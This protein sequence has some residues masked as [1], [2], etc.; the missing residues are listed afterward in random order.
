MSQVIL[1]LQSGGPVNSSITIGNDTINKESF[2]NLFSDEA[3]SKYLATKNVDKKD[4]E[5]ITNWVHQLQDGI[6][7]N[8]IKYDGNTAKIYDTSY[9]VH[10]D[11]GK[12]YQSIA[13]GVIKDF[14]KNATLA[15]PTADR[16]KSGGIE[17]VTDNT[18]ESTTAPKFQFGFLDNLR[19]VV[20]KG[21]PEALNES[22][23]NFVKNPSWDVWKQ[24]YDSYKD[25]IDKSDL[26]FSDTTFK[27]KEAYQKE[28]SNLGKAI[29]NK[30]INAMAQSFNAIGEPGIV[31]PVSTTEQ[32]NLNNKVQSKG[33]SISTPVQSVDNKPQNISSKGE[34]LSTSPMDWN[35]LN[36]NQ[37]LDLVSFGLDAASLGASFIPGYGNLASGGLGLLGTAVSTINGKTDFLGTL[38]NV[39]LD[40]TG[41][42]PG[43]G[44]TAKGKK[45]V[46]AAKILLPIVSASMSSDMTNAVKE[47]SEGKF[48]PANLAIITTS[49]APAIIRNAK[50]YSISKKLNPQVMHT[51]RTATGNTISV[52]P[53][54]LSKITAASN[55]VNQ[56]NVIKNITGE[57]VELR[58][59]LNNPLYKIINRNTSR[60][61]VYP[62]LIDNKGNVSR[63]RVGSDADIATGS[64]VSINK[65]ITKKVKS[66]KLGSYKDTNEK[67]ISP[68]T[69]K[70]GGIIKAQAGVKTSATWSKDMDPLI[71]PS[72]LFGLGQNKNLYKQL[73]NLQNSYYGI[74][75]LAGDNFENTAYKSPEVGKY[76]TE[77]NNVLNGLGNN[78]AMKKLEDTNKFTF[79]KNANT[80]D[81]VNTWNDNLFSGMTN[82]RYLLGKK[83]DF[84]PEQEAQRKSAFA[85]EGY[86][87]YLDYNNMYKLKPINL[88]EQKLNA[89]VNSPILMGTIKP[90]SVEGGENVKTPWYNKLT[91]NAVSHFGTLRF[92]NNFWYNSRIKPN[93]IGSYQ[94]PVEYNAKVMYDLPSQMAYNQQAAEVNR[95]GARTVSAD[96][97]IN[98]ANMLEHT[99]LANE[100]QEKG[101]LANKRAFDQSLEQA[102]KIANIN[103][104]N[105]VQAA[106]KN[107]EMNAGIQNAR[108]SF[109]LAQNRQINENFDNFLQEVE[110]KALN[111]KEITRNID[112]QAAQ[113]FYSTRVQKAADALRNAEQNYKISNPNKQWLNSQEYLNA[114]R[115]YD[116]DTNNLSEEFYQS[117]RNLGSQSLSPLFKKGGSLSEATQM[118]MHNDD[119]FNKMMRFKVSEFDKMMKQLSGF[120]TK[121]IHN[122]SKCK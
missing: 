47:I 11:L 8:K 44:I 2:N 33:T 6:N 99:K 20:S 105:R 3:I 113:H 88:V 49:L 122:N 7:N 121:L 23:S 4:I 25:Y 85:K 82:M 115:A 73:N 61:V 118:I 48:T 21:N 78:F 56:Q 10:D 109:R 63:I 87:W 108:E 40:I 26:D 27:S 45:L 81:K 93:Y 97:S 104:E 70:N 94:T 17:S 111:N 101:Q 107:A 34:S 92:L 13:L 117:M 67:Y 50:S 51:I 18:K 43:L 24:A 28:L 79:S 57:A 19:K 95:M 116:V 96:Q 90:T 103:T 53:E 80:S 31:N 75:T 16:V 22:Y 37:K 62:T 54:E 14:S 72:I 35:K 30:D 77:F 52:T 110:K 86:N 5:P 15:L 46:N 68:Q 36:T 71:T 89:D 60:Q 112:M 76:Q 114:R 38:G 42:I 119:E 100:L 84:T 29:S 32:P 39:G 58:H 106:D 66:S 64:K 59:N 1:K 12:K 65:D 91:D 98:T 69:N 102:N 9:A 120:S 74:K 41:M 83:G 55:K